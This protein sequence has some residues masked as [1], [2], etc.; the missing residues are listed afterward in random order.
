LIDVQMVKVR[1]AL[2]KMDVELRT[3]WG[4]GGWSIPAARRR[5]V[6]KCL[7][8]QSRFL[9]FSESVELQ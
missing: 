4:S 6:A 8:R 2:E 5:L 7:T 9:C 3:E 1:K